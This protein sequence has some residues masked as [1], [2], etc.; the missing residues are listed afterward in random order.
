[1]GVLTLAPSSVE[2]SRGTYE[3]VGGDELTVLQDVSDATY[4]HLKTT[5]PTSLWGASLRIHFGA[6][7]MPDGARCSKIYLQ[8]RAKKT[9]SLSRT[10]RLRI[11]EGTQF[12]YVGTLGTDYQHAASYALSQNA[13]IITGPAITQRPDGSAIT[14]ITLGRLTM[15][16]YQ[17]FH[18]TVELLKANVI[19]EYDEK[20]TIASIDQDGGIQS[21]SSPLI[22]W[23]YQD[24]TQPQY[25]YQVS[26]Y[27]SNGSLAYASGK[28]YTGDEFHQVQSHLPDDVYTVQVQGAQEWHGPGG[29][30]WSDIRTATVTIKSQVPA[31]PSV[32]ATSDPVNGR[33]IIDVLSN[34]NKLSYESA[35]FDF[36]SSPASK[37][38]VNC[39][40][41]DEP[42]ETHSGNYA[43]RATLTAAN[44]I[45]A[46]DR[47]LQPAKPGVAYRASA[48]IK[49]RTGSSTLN[50]TVNIRF[51]DSSLG[52]LSQTAGSLVPESFATPRIWLEAF[53]AATAPVST[54]YVD[55]TVSYSGG[56]AAAQHLIDDCEIRVTNASFADPN[57]V[58]GISRGGMFDGILPNMFSYE[59]FSAEL[60][61]ISWVDYD[62]TSAD[63]SVSADF[64]WHGEASI[65]F[66]SNGGGDTGIT[67]DIL[68]PVVPGEIYFLRGFFTS[69]AVIRQ[70]HIDADFY[71]QN[72]INLGT[73]QNP[74]G[75]ISSVVGVWTE[76]AG[77]VTVPVGSAFMRVSFHNKSTADGE[78]H[79]WDGMMCV[80]V[81]DLA[82]MDPGLIIGYDSG[83]QGPYTT[84]EYSEDAGVTWSEL[85]TVNAAAESVTYYDAETVQG[86][87]RRY[88][89]YNWKIVGAQTILS[90]KSPETADVTVAI[91]Q[92]W[93]H[94]ED[95]PAGTLY[96]FLYWTGSRNDV[97]DMGGVLT[98]FVG[99]DYPMAS[100][101]E[102]TRRTLST[103]IGLASPA[104]RAAF[105]VLVT[106]KTRIM[107]RDRTGR[108]A[109]GIISNVSNT[110]KPLGDKSVTFD[111][112]YSG[113]QP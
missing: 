18:S 14:N 82:G 96:G 36:R 74:T 26:I 3:A 113:N 104:D 72:Q 13:G 50:T 46:I 68:Y 107:Y 100:F 83:E 17:F 21:I 37:T 95:D 64:A 25:A 105:E 22:S 44:P 5:Y 1:M 54:A 57:R 75:V 41:D 65:L 16:I 92:T 98:D 106:K 23:D 102:T 11:E 90:S 111:F 69:A 60:T 47:I 58:G 34:L 32:N 112:I 8:V 43:L 15:E 7:A 4:V 52:L 42:V 77:T 63:V 53:A 81:T 71:D 27:A 33:V 49:A 61:P 12:H 110:D 30:F 59:D 20:P 48:W 29:E 86:I 31:P 38:E 78:L 76:M 66:A 55:M 35:H 62:P 109:W 103:G 87:N 94:A 56:V 39:T 91:T 19:V 28:Q 24:D 88:R 99:R 70:F 84:I 40:V 45:V 6:Q 73:Q 67:T 9:T 108:R 101:G 80:N 79:Y 10:L 85:A 2:E 89:A 97:P 93:M 51:F